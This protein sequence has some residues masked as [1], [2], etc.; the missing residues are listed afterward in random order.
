[1]IL[2]VKCLGFQ[3]EVTRFNVVVQGGCLSKTI[4]KVLSRSHGYFLVSDPTR[5]RRW[6]SR[7]FLLPWACYLIWFGGLVGTVDEKPS[8]WPLWLGVWQASLLA[9]FPTVLSGKT[10]QISAPF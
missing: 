3:G 7:Q 2:S 1:M 8:W 9:C 4:W 6:S 10:L 5:E